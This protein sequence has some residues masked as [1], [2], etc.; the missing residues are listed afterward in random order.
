VSFVS[1]V[2]FADGDTLHVVQPMRSQRVVLDRKGRVVR[3]RPLI[4]ASLAWWRSV[5]LPGDELLTPGA[6]YDAEHVGYPMH[7][8]GANGAIRRSLGDDSTEFI[9]E[10]DAAFRVLARH[11]ASRVWVAAPTR[12]R[13]ERWTLDGRRDLTLVRAAAWFHDYDHFDEPTTTRAP[14]PWI[15]DLHED[16]RGLLWVL[17]G[18]ADPEWRTSLVP[19][20]RRTTTVYDSR[21]P[22]STYDT[23]I[24]VIDPSCGT[25][26]VSQRLPELMRKVL[27]DG[28]M[29]SWR[30]GLPSDKTTTPKVALWRVDATLPPAGT[31]GH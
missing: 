6:I 18:V 11:D 20:R 12:Y 13:I 2:A 10:G 7:V 5:L 8:I 17:V 30:V 15:I 23:I 21:T 31:C 22:S 1:F 3:T 4:N 28:Y 24:E 16:Q 14:S 9:S 19:R 27:D 29:A 26:L 25:V